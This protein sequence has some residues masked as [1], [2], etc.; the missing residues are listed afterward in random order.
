MTLVYGE[1]L[2]ARSS[3][4]I[5]FFKQIE[6]KMTKNVS[7]TL[8]HHINERGFAYFIKGNIRIQITTDANIYFYLMDKV[9]FMPD[10][11]NVMLNY[12][13]CN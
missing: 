10:L 11:E 7:W 5:L 3:S 6:D 1:A 12:M 8:Y 9:T 4:Q 2:V 13:G